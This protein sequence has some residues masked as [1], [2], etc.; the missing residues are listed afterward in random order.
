MK[1]RRIRPVSS[2]SIIHL[3]TPSNI[4]KHL[5]ISW[6]YP[7]ILLLFIIDGAADINPLLALNHLLF[8]AFTLSAAAFG[9]TNSRPWTGVNTKDEESPFVWPELALIWKEKKKKKVN[10]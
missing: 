5:K 8:A 9:L 1:E 7:N 3:Q 6:Y 10:E 2:L 4:L